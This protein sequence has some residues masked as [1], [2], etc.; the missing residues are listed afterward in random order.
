M[1]PSWI[2]ELIFLQMKVTQKESLR[3]WPVTPQCMN[4]CGGSPRR[5]LGRKCTTRVP[6]EVSL[7]NP[8]EDGTR[9]SATYTTVLSDTEKGP[10]KLLSSS[11]PRAG[12]RA[13]PPPC[14]GG[15]VSARTAWEGEH[16]ST[17]SQHTR[18]IRRRKVS[19]EGGCGTQLYLRCTGQST[20]FLF[21]LSQCDWSLHPAP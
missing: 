12:C 11:I 17:F 5:P 1:C 4:G 21:L 15:N 20:F 7:V 3:A 9:H 13:P 16:L 19:R 18:H 14:F 2:D 6:V 10:E 8:G